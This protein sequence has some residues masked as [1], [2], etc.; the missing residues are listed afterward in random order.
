MVRAVPV[1]EGQLDVGDAGAWV[2]VLGAVSV[3]GLVAGAV[4]GAGSTGDVAE[5]PAA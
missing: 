3:V 4:L 5:G 1:G 2:A